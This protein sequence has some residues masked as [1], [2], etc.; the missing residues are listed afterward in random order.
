M[1]KGGPMLTA[2]LRA[3]FLK[4]NHTKTLKKVKIMIWKNEINLDHLNQT[5][6]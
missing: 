2:F 6:E 4:F 1:K 3:C 5:P